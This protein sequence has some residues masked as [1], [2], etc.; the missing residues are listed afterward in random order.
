MSPRHLSCALALGLLSLC[1]QAAETVKLL[2][3]G[4]VVLDD[5]AGA[6]IARGDDPFKGFAPLFA[7]ADIRLANLECVVAT[8]GSAGDK[9]Y[10]FRAHPRVLPV[11]KKHFDALALAN[12][13]SGDYGREAF[14][15]M[16]GL[17][18]GAGIGQFGGGHNLREAHTPLIIER[19]GVRIALL[20][21]NE[22]M[23]RSFEADYNAPGS[24]WSEDERVVADIRAARTVH[25]AD[26]VIPVMHW[27]WEN[28][29]V[30]NARQRQLAR[31]MVAAGADA[32]IGGHPHVR[33]D[34]EIVNGKP[35]VYSVGNFVMKETDNANQRLGWVLELNLDKTGVAS[36][37]THTAAID[38]EGIPTPASVSGSPCG[39]RGQTQPG[40]CSA[41]P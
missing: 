12:N 2:F 38:M 1:A 27:G 11:L 37:R 16:L 32:V 20:G 24:A 13:H 17:L 29:L 8:T 6:M 36:W 18:K 31:T 7:K 28:E 5:T 26:L 41:A 22:F 14:A 23:P 39:E 30:A 4:D 34:I 40:V 15:E 19:K 33:Q 21:Y 35:V 3:A 10:T 9:N 25:R